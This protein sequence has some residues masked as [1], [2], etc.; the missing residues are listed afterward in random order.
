MVECEGELRGG[1]GNDLKAIVRSQMKT[2]VST[3]VT[4]FPVLLKHFKLIPTKRMVLGS[5]TDGLGLR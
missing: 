2:C 1:G 3:P 4:P 5:V